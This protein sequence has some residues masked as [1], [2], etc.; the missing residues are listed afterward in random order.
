MIR[1]TFGALAGV[2]LCALHLCAQPAYTALDTV[3]AYNM[4]H[5]FGTN[6]GWYNN[7]WPDAKLAD[8]AAGNPDL[9]VP[10]IGAR[11]LRISLPEHHLEQWG[12]AIE[13]ADIQHYHHL[14]MR[15]MTAFLQG[16]SEA[17]RLST[18][19]CPGQ[20]SPHL[21]DNMYLPIWDDGLDGTPINDSNYYARYVYL[22]ATQYSDYIRFW[23]VLNE[24]DYTP[25]GFGW[26]PSGQEGS[27]FDGPPNPCDLKNLKAPIYHYI[28]MMRIAYE[29][30]KTVDPTAYVAIGGIGYA[31]F[32]DATL[33]YTD[34]P[35]DGSPSA[36]FP[37]TGGA[38]F[39]AVSYHAYPANDGSLR[40]YDFAT[41]QFVHSRHSDA[42]AEGVM[43]LKQT[44]AATLADRGYDGSVYPS[45]RWLVTESNVS[46]AVFNEQMGSTDG[47]RN[48]MPKVMVRAMQYG[49]DQFYTFTLGDKKTAAAANN[50]W[51]L[52]GFYYALTQ[53]PPYQEQV[54]PSGV[55]FK[56]AADL[57]HQ[58][59]RYDTAATAELEM[60]ETVGGG[61]FR[62]EE[63]QLLLVLW[64]KTTTDQSEAASASYSFPPAI[65]FPLFK[66]RRWDYSQTEAQE[67]FSERTLALDGSPIFLLA[68]QNGIAQ[69]KEPATPPF[70]ASIRPNLLAPGQ[71]AQLRLSTQH[72]TPLTASLLDMSGRYLR[73]IVSRQIVAPGQHTWAVDMSGLP[74]GLYF[75]QVQSAMGVIN[76]KMV[77]H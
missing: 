54:T 56:T 62:D 11:N 28:R 42:A 36:D 75:C 22:A 26:R 47:Q 55:A 50:A 17:H 27:W 68:D 63:D 20:P 46:R 2:L 39:D 4:P 14:G 35:V 7:N 10:G 48:F 6:L 76:I 30:I 58:Y 16:P 61:A 51:D 66:L 33:R 5:Y 18:T 44:L 49:I 15:E 40:Y 52:M 45:K 1:N 74:A 57:L 38:Y 41:A 31:S 21:F 37:L 60:P 53:T 24:P 23:E 77:C 67:T 59:H 72:S 69:R 43:N 8:I 9:G 70:T 73:S 71:P 12:Y 29:V 19:F 3:P 34:N 32:L 13:L 25:T 65:L 64:A